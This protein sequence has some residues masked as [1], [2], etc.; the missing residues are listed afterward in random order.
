[1][2]KLT[3]FKLFPLAV[4]LVISPSLTGELTAAERVPKVPNFEPAKKW[5]ESFVGKKKAFIQE[6]FKKEGV[7]AS[8]WDNEG[9]DELLLISEV[10]GVEVAFY[11]LGDKVILAS[12]DYSN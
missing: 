6:Y 11:F 3:G 8:T 2:N 4:L 10:Q 1:M 9:V 7:K 5:V 12:L